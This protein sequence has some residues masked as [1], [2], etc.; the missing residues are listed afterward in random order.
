MRGRVIDGHLLRPWLRYWCSLEFRNFPPFLIGLLSGRQAVVVFR[1]PRRPILDAALPAPIF[2][3]QELVFADWAA[4][5]DYFWTGRDRG[6]L[7]Y[8]ET[9]YVDY[10]LSFTAGTTLTQTISTPGNFQL[11][12][13]VSFS[14]LGRTGPTEVP[15]VA[16]DKPVP[17]RFSFTA[18]AAWG[19][20]NPNGVGFNPDAFLLLSSRESATSSW[21]RPTCSCSGDGSAASASSTGV[22]SSLGTS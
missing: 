9:N 10:Y 13:R 15:Y 8:G 2:G 18:Q 17:F 4:T 19:R 20:V 5:A 14:P 12:G 21:R 6:V 7:F 3:P 1:N 11:I 16:T 22:V